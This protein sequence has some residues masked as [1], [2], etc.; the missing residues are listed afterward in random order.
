MRRWFAILACSLSAFGCSLLSGLEGLSGGGEDGG[1]GALAEAGVEAGA[2]DGTSSGALPGGDGGAVGPPVEI[3]VASAG[4]R[5]TGLASQIHLVW[6][7]AT[8][9]WVL[10]FFDGRAD[11]RTRTSKDF[12][13]WTPGASIAAPYD[14]RNEGRNLSV[15]TTTVGTKDALHIAL[16][17]KPTSTDRRLFWMRALVGPGLAFGAVAEIARTTITDGDLDPD[18]SNVVVG[19]DGAVTL[20]TGWST[21]TPGDTS[22]TGNPYLFRSSA[23]DRGEAFA[24][25]WNKTVVEVVPQLVNAR[26]ALPIDGSTL[27]TFHENAAAEPD[28]TNL[29]WS[30][31][32]PGGASAPQNVFPADAAFDLADW[33]VARVSAT[34]LHAVRL[35]RGGGFDHRRFDGGAWKAGGEVPAEPLEVGRGVVLVRASGA[36]SLLGIAQG[37]SA[38]RRT[39]WDGAAWSAWSTVVAGGGAVRSAL[40]ASV[41]EG[42]AAVVW[43]EPRA[44]GASAVVGL[45]L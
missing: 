5:V 43:T 23:S 40:S 16:S 10:V 20:L 39:T 19:V 44:G 11:L 6:A 29:R 37:S 25:T 28:P 22:G 21:G 13:T 7:A 24:P 26:S 38:V 31:V 4:E 45:A 34:D 30:L 32:S 18:G 36:L 15:A 2:L 35:R 1:G 33:S 9:T 14:H 8:Q 17:V 27:L 3:A 42:R 12:R 41:G